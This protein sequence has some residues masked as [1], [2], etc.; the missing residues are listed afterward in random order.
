MFT[1]VRSETKQTNRSFGRK[2]CK[3]R[4]YPREIKSLNSQTLFF[5]AENKLFHPFSKQF[6]QLQLPQP[7]AHTCLLLPSLKPSRDSPHLFP[8]HAPSSPPSD[9][10]IWHQTEHKTCHET[11]FQIF[12]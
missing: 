8:P 10:T 5:S 6:S 9:R 7:Y 11:P 4:I 1:F 3:D 12:N 2:I